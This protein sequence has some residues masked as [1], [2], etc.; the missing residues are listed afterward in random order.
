MHVVVLDRLADA[1]ATLARTLAEILGKTAYECRPLVSAPGGGPVIAA[2]HAHE[3]EALAVAQQLRAAGL[4]ATVVADSLAASV[5]KL[6]GRSFELGDT[7]IRIQSRDGQ[8]VVLPFGEIEVVVRGSVTTRS[9][10]TETTTTRKL[11]VGRA[12]LTG[13]LMMTR[14][15]K[16][17]HTTTTTDSHG[18]MIVF[19]RG[20]APPVVP[21]VVLDEQELQYQSLGADMQPSRMAN[22]LHLAGQ[23]RKRSPGATW[24]ERLLRRVAQQQMLG[25]TLSAD[26]HLDLAIALIA[27]SARRQRAEAGQVCS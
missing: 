10:Q 12:V 18:F 4:D 16:T 22:F 23:L 8:Q 11:D 1:P 13:G 17:S 9:S 2:C 25:T 7:A 6:I 15:H 19:S 5:R 24:D 3:A 21:P 14:K 26:E 27:A 20:A